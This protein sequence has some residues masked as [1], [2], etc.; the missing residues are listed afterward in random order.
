[1]MTGFH[2]PRY[3]IPTLLRDIYPEGNEC[4]RIHRLTRTICSNSSPKYTWNIDEQDKLKPSGF[5]INS[6]IDGYSRKLLWLKVLCSSNSFSVLEVLIWTAQKK[7][8]D[9]QLS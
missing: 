3:T 8:R 7:W 2:V 4:R 5:T 9:A 6:A 1:M